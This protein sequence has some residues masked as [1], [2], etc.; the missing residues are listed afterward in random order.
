M[1]DGIY[2]MPYDAPIELIQL[3]I[4]DISQGRPNLVQVKNNVPP[5]VLL[6]H[7]LI[8]IFGVLLLLLMAVLA[9]IEARYGIA[10]HILLPLVTRVIDV[11]QLFD[12]TPLPQS[13]R[14]SFGVE[15]QNSTNYNRALTDAL[16]NPG[17]QLHT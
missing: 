10:L 16:L 12:L 5:Q 3:W 9:T 6:Y 15:A 4:D 11:A 2:N 17:A 14:I 1:V 8:F 7:V 13:K